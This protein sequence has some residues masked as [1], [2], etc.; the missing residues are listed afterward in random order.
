MLLH[1]VREWCNISSGV[2]KGVVKGLILERGGDVDKANC[3]WP[4][5]FKV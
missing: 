3:Y 2:G 5:A 4:G 1:V